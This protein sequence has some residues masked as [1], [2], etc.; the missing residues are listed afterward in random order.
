MLRIPIPFLQYLVHFLSYSKLKFHHKTIYI[1]WDT[2]IS[3][4]RISI[5]NLW[6]IDLE[7]NICNLWPGNKEPLLYFKIY[8]SRP[9][10]IAKRTGS[11]VNWTPITLSSEWSSLSAQ[12]SCFA[13][14]ESSDLCHTASLDWISALHSPP[15]VIFLHFKWFKVT[16]LE[17]S[18]A[19][20]TAFY[21][22]QKAGHLFSWKSDPDK[23]FYS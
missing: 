5:A 17:S 19:P 20:N 10:H 8:I 1:H 16:V 6:R 14:I 12:E 15:P 18:P 2:T 13:L 22:L 11:K 3:V 21:N 7:T 9:P 23:C 4:R